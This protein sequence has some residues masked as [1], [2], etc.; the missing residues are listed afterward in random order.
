MI[1]DRLF[2][3]R[4]NILLGYMFQLRLGFPKRL[5]ISLTKIINPSNDNA[6]LKGEYDRS[7]VNILP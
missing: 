1:T 4:D 6:T 2:E 5:N 7:N 3:Y